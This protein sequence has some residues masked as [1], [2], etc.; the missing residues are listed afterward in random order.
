M[1]VCDRDMAGG[2]ITIDYADGMEGK[3]DAGQYE[4]KPGSYLRAFKEFGDAD[5]HRCEIAGEGEFEQDKA[6]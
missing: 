6:H 4:Q 1:R 3:T 2:D 5:D